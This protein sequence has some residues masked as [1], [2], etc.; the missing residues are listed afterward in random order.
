MSSSTLDND[1]IPTDVQV[2]AR[3]IRIR[4]SG[5]LELATPGDRFPRFRNADPSKRT[6]W[7]LIG[8]APELAEVA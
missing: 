8:R 3:M 7:E 2:D 4:F 5:G 6:Q 1:Y